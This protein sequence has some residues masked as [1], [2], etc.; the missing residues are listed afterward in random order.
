[1]VKTRGGAKT[2]IL[3]KLCGNQPVKSGRMTEVGEILSLLDFSVPSTEYICWF[4]WLIL[5]SL[6]GF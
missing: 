3:C 6:D 5:P 4:I 1:M 2:R